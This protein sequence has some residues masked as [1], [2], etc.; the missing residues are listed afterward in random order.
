[1]GADHDPRWSAAGASVPRFGVEEEFLVVDPRTGALTPRAAAVAGR[2][3]ERLGDRITGEITKWQLES[4]T[5]PCASAVEL[6]DQLV[7]GRA[8]LGAAATAE[9]LAVVATGSPVLAGAVP[10]PITEGPRQDRGT[11]T[12]R[13][14][15][16]ELSI[17]ALH[18]HV[19]LPDRERAVL[20]SNHLRPHLPLL[21]ALT[22]NSP[23]WE[24]RDT[25]YA[26]W[27]T[28]TWTRWPVAG[29]PPYLRSAEHYTELVGTLLDAGALVDSG[30]VFWD[31]RPS[32][33]HPTLEV[34]V[35]DVPITAAESALYAALVRALVGYLSAAVGRGEPGPVV[36]PELMRVA[37]WRAARDGLDGDAVDLRT[38]RLVP[39]VDLLGEL[40]ELLGPTLRAYG[41]HDLVDSGLRILLA[42]GTGAVRQR[43]AAASR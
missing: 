7:E 2:A 37:Y 15:H 12:F 5:D 30:T 24:G 28:R 26:S 21:I 25:G 3:R 1:M 11:A 16:D 4:R 42:E 29:P 33:S 43:A 8:A 17:C 6:L 10:P 18:V 22:A 13:G 40:V 14:L 23:Y 38:G 41:D 27:R 36:P 39:A 32:D 9:E 19:E 31:V 20:V 35:S 34:R